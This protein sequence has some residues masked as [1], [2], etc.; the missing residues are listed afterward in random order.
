MSALYILDLDRTLLDVDAAMKIAENA[1]HKLKVDFS[2][3]KSDQQKAFKN[4]I[5]YSPLATIDGLEEGMLPKFKQ[6]FLSLA[7]PEMLVFPDARRYIDRLH[8]AGSQYLILTYAR[9]ERWQE[10]KLQAAGLDMVPHV[11][12][13]HPHKS[14]DIAKWQSKDGIFNPPV[15]GINPAQKIIFVDDRLRVFE[16][17]PKNCHAFYLKRSDWQ[18][19]L[20]PNSTGITQISS[21]DELVDKL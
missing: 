9:D 13:L 6:V 14:Q 19:D 20:S 10:L 16:G 3:I 2:I 8:R 5:P 21:F 12:L 1:C 4:A 7:K 18:E 11:I 17:M 15:E